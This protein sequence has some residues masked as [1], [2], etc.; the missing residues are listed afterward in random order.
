MLGGIV[1]GI[2]SG[3]GSTVKGIGGAV[4]E[5]TGLS[6]FTSALGMGGLNEPTDKSEKAAKVKAFD[7]DEAPTKVLQRISYRSPNY[8]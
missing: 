8:S 4:A 5:T 3:I 1:K 6:D 7:E 2:G